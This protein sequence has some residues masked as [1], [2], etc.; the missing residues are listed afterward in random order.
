MQI[1]SIK[2]KFNSTTIEFKCSYKILPSSLS[3]IANSFNLPKKLSFPYKFAS[4]D[5]LNYKGHL[6]DISFFNTPNDWKNLSHLKYF[7]FK[8]YSIEYCT[9]DVIITADFIKIIKNILNEFNIKFENIY[10]APSLSLKIFIKKFNNNKIS[11][12]HNFLLDKIIRP[13]YYG[14]KCEV[15]ANPNENDF[16]FHFDFSGMYAQCMKQKFPFGKYKIETQCKN[17]DKPGFYWIEAESNIPHPILPHHRLK[18]NKLLFTNGS[19]KGCYWYEEIK[20][21]LE[22]NGRIKKINYYINF[23]NYDYIFSDFIDFFEKIRSK[24]NA[25]KT[26][27]KLIINSLYGRLGMKYID[28]YSMFIHKNSFDEYNNNIDIISHKE[29]NDIILIKAEINERLKKKLNINFQR[30]KTNIPIAATITSKAR[31]KLYNAQQEVIKNNG[32][33]LYS[34]TDSIFAAYSHDVSN[35]KHGEIFWDVSKNNTKIKDAVFIAPKSYGI[36]YN[37]DSEIIKIKGYNQKNI[38]FKDLKKQFYTNKDI[39]IDNYTYIE[40]NSLT[41]RELKTKKIISLDKYDK[42]KFENNKKNT[43]PLYYNNYTY[44]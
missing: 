2:I 39:I 44:Y 13:G 30:T 14:G 19:I 32:K 38:K 12:R 23:E 11:F 31:I 17:I 21:F 26:F 4:L 16:I 5:N 34:D 35:Q 36:L 22:H 9:R 41:L 25:Y 6:P 10:S 33:L 8:K 40:K 20:L 3:V 27:G 15:Y 1:Y 24:E 7:D 18:D 37:D 43:S 42:R 28:T 29:L